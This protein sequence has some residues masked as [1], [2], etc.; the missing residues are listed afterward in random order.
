M[1]S[2]SCS[3]CIPMWFRECEMNGSNRCVFLDKNG[4]FE[5][6][7]ISRLYAMFFW[8]R[9]CMFAWDDRL[10]IHMTPRPRPAQTGFAIFIGHVSKATFYRLMW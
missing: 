1:H 7:P 9:L 4:V 10:V 5:G 8:S 6:P 2:R 3:D